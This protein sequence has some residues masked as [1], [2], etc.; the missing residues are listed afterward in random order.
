MTRERRLLSLIF[1]NI[2]ALV[3]LTLLSQG[4]VPQAAAQSSTATPVRQE[5]AGRIR[6]GVPVEGVIDN[7]LPRQV[8]RFEASGGA[9]VDIR[10]QALSGNLDPFLVLISPLGDVLRTNDSANGGLDA[11]ILAY[12]LP[13][14]GEYQIVARRTGENDG[15]GGRTSGTYRLTLDLRSPNTAAQNTILFVG[16]T[17][18]GRLTDEQP[19]A[20]YRLELGGALA[21]RLDLDGANRIASVR[22][23]TTSGT[24]LGEYQGLSPL[25]VALNL[26][27]AGTALVEVSAPSYEERTAADFALSVYRL[28][29]RSEPPK[30][31]Q[32][33]KLRYAESPVTSQWFFIGTAGDVLALSVQAESSFGALDVDVT[34]GI[35]NEL[36]L[37]RGVLGIGFE[38]VFTLPSTGAYS[39]ELRTPAGQRFRY[40][41]LLRQLG[42]NN[43]PFE[44]FTTLRDQGAV[45]FNTAIND[46]LPRGE[47][48]S[49][50]LD[51]TADQVITVRAAPRSSADTLG[52]AI[53]RPDGTILAANVSRAERGAV[54]QNVLLAPTGRYRIAVFELALQTARESPIAYT[55]RVEDTDGGT[56]RPT[57][58]VK[59]VAT[60]ANGLSIWEITATADSL[61]SVRLEN[62]TPAAWQPELFVL[63][64]NGVVIAAARGETR[65][66][67]ALAVLGA[68]ASESG[69]YRVVVGGRVT[70][71]FATYRLVSGVQEPFDPPETRQIAIAPLS[72]IGAPDRYAPTPTPPPIRL[73]VAEQ[74]SPLISPSEIPADQIAPLPF[75]TT[76]RGE[77]SNGSLV[78]AWRINS[79][80]NVVIQLRATALEGNS[81]PRLTLWDRNGRIVGEQLNAQG[82]V[83]FFTY[84]IVQG[85]NYTV[86]VSMGLNGG[87]YLLALDAQPLAETLRVSDGVPLTYGQTVA[88]ELQSSLETDTYFFLGTLNDV[89]S[90][91]VIRATGRL[92]PALSLFGP[93][94]REL[95][96]DRPTDGRY[97]AELKNV[98]L[99]ESGLYR[100][101]VSDVSRAERVEGRYLISLGLLSATRL[102]SR[103]GGAIREGEVRS[104]FLLAGDNEDTWLFRARRGQRVS[105]VLFSAEPPAP[106]PLSLQ[107][108]DTSG[109]LFAAQ[110]RTLPQGVVRLEDVLL[111]EDG[112]YR[113]RVVG[114]A[115]Q[116]GVYRLQWLS[117]DER[118][119]GVISYGQTVS[120]I[121]T[122]ARNFETWVFSGNVGDVVS[123]ALRYVRGTPFTASFQLRAANGVPLATVADLEGIG[124][125]ADVLLP[126]D[127]SYSI[128]VANPIPEFQGAS[129]YALT[130]GLTESRARAIGGV[131]RYGDEAVSTL[132]AD[133]GIDTWVF[134]AQAGERVRVTVQA[135]DRFLAPYLE[136]RSAADEVLAAALP[137]P[138]PLAT[139]RLGGDGQND[140]VIPA[141]G[142]YA[143]I[144][145]GLP[146]E[147]GAPST[148]SYRISLDFTPRPA[149]EIERL[150]YGSAVNGV[151]AD[152]RPQETYLFEGRQGDV[153]TAQAVR[154]SGASLSLKVQL[155]SADGQILAVAD[156]DDGDSAVLRDFRLPETGKYRLAVLR[157][158]ERIGQTAGRY[159]VRLDGVP[160][161][162]AVR[163]QV[164]Y[165]QQVLGRLTDSVPIDRLAFEGRRGDVISVVTRATSGDLDTVLRLEREDGSLVAI[166]DDADG[167]NAALSGVILPEDGRYII[168]VTRVGTRTAGSA[169]NYE[170]F[171]N[172][173]YQ[174]SNLN[175]NLQPIGYGTRLVGTLDA[176]RV[177]SRYVFRGTQGDQIVVQLLHQNDDAPPILELRDPSD[178]LLAS[179]TL[180][181]GRTT[182]EPFSLPADGSYQL[183]VRRPLNSR[184]RFSPFALTLDLTSISTPTA[185]GLNGGVLTVES[186]V[187]GTF[188]PA[189]TAHYWL[190]SGKAGQTLSL[191]LLRLSGEGL[192]TLIVISPNGQRI[193]ETSTTARTISTTLE[194]LRLPQDG[195]YTLLVLP[196][197][198]GVPS[199]YRLTV[200]R[201]AE[202]EATLPSLTSGVAANGVLDAVRT[203]DLWQFE[204]EAG[205]TLS[206]RLLVT[207]GNLQPRLLLLSISGQVLAEGALLRTA[208]GVSSLIVSYPIAESDRYL[209]QTERA[210]VTTSG[211]YR[212]LLELGSPAKVPSERAVAASRVAYNQAVRGVIASQ[213]ETLWAFIGAAGDVVNI[214]VVANTP[215]GGAPIP[216]PYLE[217]QDV[218]GRAL[219]SAAPQALEASESAVQGL[220]LP[221]DGRYILVMRSEK[222]VP[223][224][225]V[226]QRRQDALPSNLA[227]APTR[228]LVAGLTL[229]NGITPN[230]GVDYWTFAG[231]A[232]EPVQ[233]EASR[234]NGDLR[235]DLA[236]YAPSGVYLAGNAAAPTL[237]SAALA[238]LRLPEDGTYLLVVTRWLGAAGR[239]NGAY[240]VR[241]VRPS[242]SQIP[243]ENEIRADDR[244]VS[245]FLSAERTAE[246]WLFSGNADERYELTFERATDALT[247]QLQLVSADGQLVSEFALYESPSALS[248]QFTL[249]RDGQ[250][251]LVTRL[252]S[253][254]GLY[255]LRLRRLQTA[256]Q[257]SIANA[258]G[259][260][261]NQSVTGTLSESSAQ[262]WVFYGKAADRIVAELVPEGDTLSGVTFSLL[263]PDGKTLATAVRFAA[264]S[265]LADIVL[266]GDGFYALA[267]R[268]ERRAPLSYRLRLTRLQP[269]ASYQGVLTLEGLAEGTLRPEQ[270]LHEWLLRP[271]TDERLV[272]RLSV[273][274]GV[275]GV[276]ALIVTAQGTL[277]AEATLQSG[278]IA[279]DFQPKAGE[280]YAVLVQN[281]SGVQGRYQL[282]VRPSQPI[283]N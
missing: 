75:N 164:R 190:L 93:S 206:A 54:L 173:L 112:V 34:V 37:F 166:N 224:T 70:G 10:M 257:A 218:S 161:T 198:V 23:F 230:D 76:V 133:D 260:A 185:R 98:R 138:L 213:R 179:G 238:P 262:A 31:L 41:V 80:S 156:S 149:A 180:G 217:I 207:N 42:A 123:V 28:A 47:V 163:S 131:L 29:A 2:S 277:I 53:L 11:G 212:L 118:S 170:L 109:Q 101:S 281:V 168:A 186:S 244:P 56:L 271:E 15:G 122:A 219:A 32:Y 283:T 265:R 106:A 21:L 276:R 3:I 25:D 232:G 175:A 16:R 20:V 220:I 4:V 66:N 125:R 280:Q 157:F 147:D 182:L 43:L 191:N 91:Q 267:I 36:P 235:L 245:G 160:E 45:V 111:P 136:L 126:F 92:V 116:Q 195:V 278:E 44:R 58:P 184:A 172:L 159:T 19:R 196:E 68:H 51:V 84:R 249:P 6:F 139:A 137:E 144:V 9:V 282:S 165:N 211:S 86:V 110:T 148:G 263:R 201:A 12:Q 254:S 82:T 63:S 178:R 225:L 258:Q 279:I 270:T 215:S 5:Q 87:R 142:A 205:Q 83:T 128:V 17:V 49:R 231:K 60:R 141:D 52:V 152:D 259:I 237:S 69:V 229:Q 264:S 96:A 176:Q 7:T 38:Q 192:P 251:R 210:D 188:V 193:G 177:E 35:P 99:P 228:A 78:Q 253:G 85:G 50:W 155:Q 255:R 169:G 275:Q 154:E 202:D 204:A 26:P 14:N 102:Q 103:G 135:T 71:N 81:A 247:A 162:R 189:E 158:G 129:I 266:P 119:G 113:V 240:R 67:N 95:A 39:I 79:G 73:S 242:E 130:L 234:L 246:T 40:S 187:I 132:Y 62:L 171:I 117:A 90:V 124:A 104:G 107:L 114:G 121:L 194:R 199:S 221:A 153:I 120:G 274:R 100:L 30:A 268:T 269:N 64:P 27:T 236:L 222:T 97:Y 134:A 146:S 151:L 272:V 8:W 61:I 167:M 174:N 252:E 226:I 203:R 65:R 233:I 208:E 183:I 145:R 55:L 57:V 140:F 243:T 13:F 33:N 197:R 200:Q 261:Y 214:S 241:L 108:L 181:V 127:G 150:G 88:A 273:A 72:G 94:G 115:Q 105:F 223:Y 227:A 1:V 250:Y 89:I 22:L 239:T 18:E 46:N 24:L 248:R 256:E 77:I 74:L 209:L 59:G 143:L 216:A 48:Q